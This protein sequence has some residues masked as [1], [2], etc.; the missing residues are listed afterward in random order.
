MK[1][2]TYD[3]P[4]C[5]KGKLTASTFTGKI[6]PRDG[7]K[8]FQ[9]KDLECCLCDS[10]GCDPVLADQTIRN[11]I[12]IVDAKRKRVG[13]LTST[14]IKDIRKKLNLTQRRASKI[15]GGGANS[16]SK[17]EQGYVV[18]SEAMDKLIRVADKSPESFSM[19]EESSKAGTNP[20]DI[21]A[22]PAQAPGIQK[23]KYL[24]QHSRESAQ[25]KMPHSYAKANGQT[26]LYTNVEQAA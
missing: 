2:S 4:V 15:F 5:W 9:I 17:Y 16:F 1:L 22:K 20:Q 7:S 18:Q 3:C 23:T 26:A 6:K 11:G 10:C 14:E 12:K 24:N 13:L 25:Y 8:P 21:P 19:L